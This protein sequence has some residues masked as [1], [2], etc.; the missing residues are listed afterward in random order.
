MHSIYLWVNFLLTFCIRAG[1]YTANTGVG[2]R[3]GPSGGVRSGAEPRRGAVSME[4][5][6]TGG[7]LGR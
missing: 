6:T 1:L 4:Q 7:Q 5:A 3:L 2:G